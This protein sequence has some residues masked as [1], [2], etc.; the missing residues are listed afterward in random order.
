MQNG[1]RRA[2]RTVFFCYAPKPDHPSRKLSA[3]EDADEHVGPSQLDE[4]EPET[5]DVMNFH[6]QRLAKLK[7]Q[8]ELWPLHI[9][10]ELGNNN[11]SQILP[12][13]H[14]RD[15]ASISKPNRTGE[16]P[17]HVAARVGNVA[18]TQTLVDLG[19][20]TNGDLKNRFNLKGLTPLETCESA[21]FRSRET[22]GVASM[23]ELLLRLSDF[24]WGGHSDEVLLVIKV[25]KQALGEEIPDTDEEWIHRNKFGCTCGQCTRGFV[26]MVNPNFL[27]N[28]QEYLY[29]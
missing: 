26:F 23:G 16:L 24:E 8:A 10:I 22:C 15:P 12:D 11:I 28:K 25:L 2:G 18:A 5:I 29:E 27:N 20:T 13:A 4:E 1:F 14:E 6:A 19:V 21:M 7:K 9:A 3:A 17:I